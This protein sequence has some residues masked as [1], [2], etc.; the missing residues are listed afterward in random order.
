M[1]RP[2]FVMLLLCLASSGAFAEPKC[3]SPSNY[4]DLIA[5]AE[6]RSPEVQSA[7]LEVE[8]SKAL[9]DADHPSELNI[10]RFFVR[11]SADKEGNI[12]SDSEWF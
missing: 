7:Q 4:S 8:R 9:I 10:I 3:T 11:K 1:K 6:S 5:C 12:K 2:L